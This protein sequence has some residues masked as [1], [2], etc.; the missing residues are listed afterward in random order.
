MFVRQCD[1]IA[2]CHPGGSHYAELYFAG[3]AGA[4]V[5]G[6]GSDEDQAVVLDSIAHCDVSLLNLRMVGRVAAAV[7]PY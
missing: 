2:S 6:L 7:G 4:P 5:A 3:I 1:R